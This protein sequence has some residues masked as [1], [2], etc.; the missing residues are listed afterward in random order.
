MCAQQAH[1]A[2]VLLRHGYAAPQQ[3][4]S[5]FVG[6]LRS[7]TPSPYSKADYSPFTTVQRSLNAFVF[8]LRTAHS[9]RFIISGVGAK[10]AA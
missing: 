10:P 5:L 1:A 8:S 3:N 7:P 6:E 4:Q 2:L 9:S